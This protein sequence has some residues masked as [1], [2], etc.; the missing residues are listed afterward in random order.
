MR[1]LAVIAPL[2][3]ILGIALWFVYW[4]WTSIEGPPMPLFGYVAL[5]GGVVAS[6]AVG[7]GLMALMFYSQ[8]RGYDDGDDPVQRR[9]PPE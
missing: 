7:I 4:A 8:R 3:V 1:G 9:R 6:L 2:V 5:V